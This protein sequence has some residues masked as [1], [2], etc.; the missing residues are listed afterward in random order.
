MSRRRAV[1]AIMLALCLVL[2]SSTGEARDRKPETCDSYTANTG[3]VVTECRRPGEKPT[4]CE[5]FTSITGT[6]KTEC[7]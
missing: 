4:H 1:A 5:S 7:R 3:T 2:I 6:T